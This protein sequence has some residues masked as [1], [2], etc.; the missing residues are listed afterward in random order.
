M[1]RADAAGLSQQP[2][3][4]LMCKVIETECKPD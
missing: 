3:D 2:L 1:L 4:M